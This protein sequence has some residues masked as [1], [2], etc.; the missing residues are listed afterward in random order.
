MQPHHDYP[1]VRSTFTIIDY[2]ERTYCVT[3]V[4]IERSRFVVDNDEII[5]VRTSREGESTEE[6]TRKQGEVLVIIRTDC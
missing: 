5:V 4:E 2:Q 6:A 3:V 1:M